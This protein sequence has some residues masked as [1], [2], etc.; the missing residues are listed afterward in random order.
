MSTQDPQ[1]GSIR[2][3]VDAILKQ[4]QASTREINRTA[5][6]L[7]ELPRMFKQS[8]ESTE[9]AL[10]DMSNL[11]LLSNILTSSANIKAKEEQINMEYEELDRKSQQREQDLAEIRQRFVKLIGEERVSNAQHI[12]SLDGRVMQLITTDFEDRVMEP[13]KLLHEARVAVNE[14]LLESAKKRAEVLDG[15]ASNLVNAMNRFLE[16]RKDFKESKVNMSTEDME[17]DEQRFLTFSAVASGSDGKADVHLHNPAADEEAEADLK[18]YINKLQSG[19]KDGSI[20]FE[21]QARANKDFVK[22]AESKS[23][24]TWSKPGDSIGDMFKEVFSPAERKTG[25]KTA[26][27]YFAEGLR[28][29]RIKMIKSVSK[30]R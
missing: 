23:D 9:K 30:K 6:S 7:Q 18:S 13:Y 19:I 27:E 24:S 20:V 11:L 10:A 22:Y 3:A 2:S 29:G 8:A 1:I 21:R 14:K 26:E 28:E 15:P 17:K 25:K 5:S 4:M 12:K 16:I